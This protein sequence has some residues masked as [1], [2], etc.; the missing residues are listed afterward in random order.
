LPPQKVDLNAA[1]AKLEATIQQMA[2]H[3][4]ELVIVPDPQIGY[5]NIDA[6]QLNQVIMN[7]VMNACDAMPHGG[8]LTIET[9]NVGWDEPQA[10][11]HPGAHA[12]G[13]VLLAVYDTGNGMD[14]TTRERLFE[15]FFSTKSR[16]RGRGLGLSTVYGVVSQSG[17]H[18]ELDTAPE[19]GTVFKIY[20]PQV[21]SPAVRYNSGV[22]NGTRQQG[23]ETVLIVEDKDE[24]RAAIG[25]SL[26]MRG[27]A[28]LK[29][30][31]GTEAVTICRRHEGPIHLLLTDIITA[32]MTGPELAERVSLV[33][34]ETK[35]LYISG[36]TGEAL[37]RRHMTGPSPAFLQKP[38]TPEVLAR[39]VRAVLDAPPPPP[40]PAR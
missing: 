35:V 25:A 38:F 8:T 26:E 20:L 12:G 39:Q 27:Y 22:R 5:V 6:S 4:I 31:H 13:Y 19:R 11:R 33:H 3:A 2:G 40:A 1:V 29:A 16:G 36:Y 28:V 30:C 18:I 15:P 14:A 23:S 34:P 24:V 7:L 21:E 32:Q 37:N 9:A 10:R 17:G